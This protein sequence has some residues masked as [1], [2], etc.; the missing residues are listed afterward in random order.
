[1]LA[2][3]PNNPQDVDNDPQIKKVHE[4]ATILAALLLKSNMTDEEKQSWMNL[5]PSMTDEQIA[6][7]EEVLITEQLG[8]IEYQELAKLQDDIMDINAKHDDK[9]LTAQKDVLAGLDDLEAEL[10]KLEEK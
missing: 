5:I 6:A 2:K 3:K 1:M 4:T 9:I 10:E 8:K 7:F